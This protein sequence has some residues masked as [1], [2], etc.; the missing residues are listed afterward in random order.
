MTIEKVLKRLERIYNEWHRFQ[1][2][3]SAAIDAHDRL[4]RLVNQIKR[5]NK[6]ITGGT[7]GGVC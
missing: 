4:R 7:N 6:A 3:D 1:G 2:S 5:E